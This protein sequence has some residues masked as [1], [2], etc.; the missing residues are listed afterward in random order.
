MTTDQLMPLETA[1]RYARQIVEWLGPYCER[2]EVAGSVRRGR[3]MCGDVDLVVIPKREVSRDL[4][5]SVMTGR[6][7]LH[8][9]L[10]DYVADPSHRASWRG[11][12]NGQGRNLLVQLKGCLLDVFCTTAEC[13]G[14][15][16]I[17]RTGSR[18]HNVWL[19]NRAK[20][21]GGQWSPYSGVI[22]D[23]ILQPAP[24]EEAVY[25][26][27]G[28]PWIPPAEREWDLLVEGFGGVT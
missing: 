27:L 19:A 23:G 14:S 9:F 8:E 10:L 4:L 26:A 2:V 6:N 11:G 17:C 20:R 24:S 5:G 7:L 15:M 25:S 18:E 3:L 28:L 1:S 16:L 21:M 12:E 13:W 22:A